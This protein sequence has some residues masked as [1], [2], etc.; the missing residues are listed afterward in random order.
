MN[1]YQYFFSIADVIN[2][3]GINIDDRNAMGYTPLLLACRHGNYVCAMHLLKM[4]NSQPQLRDNEF[5]CNA[6]DW[7]IRRFEGV[8]RLFVTVCVL[9]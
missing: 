9:L 3:F 5:F 2:K 1:S 8:A 4:G 6:R 7:T